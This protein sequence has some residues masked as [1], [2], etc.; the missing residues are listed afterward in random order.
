MVQSDERALLLLGLLTM[1]PQHG[2]QI[3]EFIE[4]N[5]GRVSLMKKATAYAMLSRME[6]AG[7]VEA[8]ED[9]EGNRPTRRVYSITPA[10]LEEML[11]MLERVLGEPDYVPPFGDIAV[12][13][14]DALEPPRAIELIR[15]RIAWM[16]DEIATM[17]AAPPHDAHQQS[18]DLGISRRIA[19]MQADRDWFADVLVKLERGEL[20]PTTL[21]PQHPETHH[22]H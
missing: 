22:G 7:L 11:R 19:L 3:N 4:Q 17:K 1:H 13:L 6:K 10:G 9:R 2:Y 8:E 21:R 16:D 14:I 20:V 5:L 18:I 12:M 15:K